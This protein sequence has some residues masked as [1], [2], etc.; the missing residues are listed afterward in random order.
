MLQHLLRI[1]CDE[2]PKSQDS[3]VIFE[4][5][6]REQRADAQVLR[7]LEV[8]AWLFCV[9]LQQNLER[10]KG[11]GSQFAV[12][13]RTKQTRAVSERVSDRLRLLRPFRVSPA[14]PFFPEIRIPNSLISLFL[15]DHKPSSSASVMPSTLAIPGVVL[16]TIKQFCGESQFAAEAHITVLKRYKYRNGLKHEFIIGGARTGESA[17]DW[18]WVRIDR[19]AALD[20]SRPSIATLSSDVPAKDSVS[21]QW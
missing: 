1:I 13:T 5:L 15:T 11:K 20:T 3:Q 7:C 6:K 19:A 12:T 16:L 10:V 17:H 9:L 8:D 2:L 21:A 18:L 14:A 4:N